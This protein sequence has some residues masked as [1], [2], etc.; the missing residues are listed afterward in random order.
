MTLLNDRGQQI[1]GE[2]EGIADSW[3]YTGQRECGCRGLQRRASRA[4]SLIDP[5]E[6]MTFSRVEE[7]DDSA[8]L[9]RM[10]LEQIAFDG[11]RRGVLMLGLPGRGKTHLAVSCINALM[12][13]GKYPGVYNVSE[14]VTRIQSTYGYT[15]SFESRHRILEEVFR[16]KVVLLDD[17]GKERK[18]Q[19]V[20]SIIYELVDGLYGR[21]R[22]LICCSN[23]PGK[24]FV[25]RYDD[26]V[27]SRL[28]GMC[29]RF[30]IK[31]DDRRLAAWD[32]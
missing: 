6:T 32:W 24:E 9:A 3:V 26:A 31:G 4:L 28:L 27:R 16:P 14:L 1:C 18:T 13:Q 19:D 15:D 20:E 5:E 11:R 10:A 7:P 2:C 12:E 30:V 29:E 25:E 23:L 8:D 21:R 22:T 17:L